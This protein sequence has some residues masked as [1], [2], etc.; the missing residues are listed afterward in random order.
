MESIWSKGKLFLLALAVVGLILPR[1]HDA[2]AQEPVRGAEA[3]E[4]EAVKLKPSVLPSEWVL[5]SDIVAPPEKTQQFE[6]RFVAV[7]KAVV[8]QAFLVN[9]R[10]EVKVNYVSCPSERDACSVYGKMIEYVGNA[11]LV[12]KKGNVVIEVAADSADVR[13]QALDLL[14]L[15]PVQRLKLK[16]GSFPEKWRL[17]KEFFVFGKE[18]EDVGVRIGV[19]PQELVNQFLLADGRVVQVNYVAGA[20]DS[21]AQAILEKM[22]SLVGGRS[23]MLKKGPVVVEIISDDRQLQ[24]EVRDLLEKA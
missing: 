23:L 20:T 21:D 3:A 10:S 18:L 8:N 19:K 24:E 13:Q 16:A 17:V 5:M 1:P 9:G 2:C 6:S 14:D 11:N 7:I 15:S 12:L 22:E 4:I